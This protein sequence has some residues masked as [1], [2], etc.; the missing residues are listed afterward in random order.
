MS[1]QHI[2]WQ[3]DDLEAIILI[4]YVITQEMLHHICLVMKSE[5]F[6]DVSLA[7]PPANQLS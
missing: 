4:L 5:T 2:C 3:L 1:V 7:Q 6:L